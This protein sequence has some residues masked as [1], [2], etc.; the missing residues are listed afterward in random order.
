MEIYEETYESVSYKIKKE[1]EKS[2]QKTVIPEGMDDDDALDMFME[3]SVTE[4]KKNDKQEE[5]SEKEAEARATIEDE[6]YFNS[7]THLFK[8]SIE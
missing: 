1:D 5:V 6:V 2:S 8:S 7:H 3:S 4:E